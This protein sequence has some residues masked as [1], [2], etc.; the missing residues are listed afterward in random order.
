M[1]RG[2][3]AF[4]NFA[5]VM[6]SGLQPGADGVIADGSNP[7]RLTGVNKGDPDAADFLF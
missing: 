6:A 2:V 1:L 4:G 7:I 3:S 5:G